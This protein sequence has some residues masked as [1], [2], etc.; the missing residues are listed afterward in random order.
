M[1]EALRRLPLGGDEPALRGG[2]GPDDDQQQGQRLHL[3]LGR[4]R[5]RRNGCGRSAS[6][7]R[8]YS[9]QDFS[10]ARAIHCLGQAW[11]SALWA[12]RSARRAGSEHPE[13]GAR[14]DDGRARPGSN[15]LLNQNSDIED[16][17]YAVLK[18]DDIIY[19]TGAAGD[20]HGAQ[21][22][23][24]DRRVRLPRLHRRELLLAHRWRALRGSPRCRRSWRSRQ[25]VGFALGKLDRELEPVSPDDDGLLVRDR[26]ARSIRI[27]LDLVGQVP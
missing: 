11:S 21:L 14:N 9:E 24:A 13:L 2:R 17:A 6:D 26:Q 7:E 23:G 1:G 4:A 25:R 27:A 15:Y 12:L 3:R 22:P 5:L 8:T 18:A 20:G 10:A 19:P 16:A